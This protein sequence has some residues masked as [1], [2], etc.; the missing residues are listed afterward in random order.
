M[1]PSLTNEILV[2]SLFKIKRLNLLDYHQDLTTIARSKKMWENELNIISSKEF[3]KEVHE[4]HVVFVLVAKEVIENSSN[5]PPKEL[6]VA[7][8]EFQDVFSS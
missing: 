5:E 6:S 8:K 4:E 7:L 1:L 2:H 3:E